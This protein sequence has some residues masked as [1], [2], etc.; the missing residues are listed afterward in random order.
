[1]S[2]TVYKIGGAPLEDDAYLSALAAH[3]KGLETPPILVHGGGKAIS[4]LQSAFGI[5]PRSIGGL[6]VTD[7]QSMALVAMALI[8]EANVNLVAR[9]ARAG[10]EAQGFS[11]ADRALL[12]SRPLQHPEGDLGRVGAVYQVRAEVLSEALRAGVVPVI[13]PIALA[14]DGGLHNINAD[15]A[16]GAIAAA[17]GARAVI[18]LTDVAGVL[19]EGAVV[20]QLSRGEAEALIATGVAAG[21][22]AVKLRAA[23]EALSAGVSAARITDIYGLSNGAG[24]LITA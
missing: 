6:R 1:M 10:V 19:R 15:Q 18:F 5:V 8:G 7:D 9:L 24:T 21:G 11:G 16:A 22:M 3:L 2:A 23:L 4:R 14:D 17:L 12:R 20:P 13:A